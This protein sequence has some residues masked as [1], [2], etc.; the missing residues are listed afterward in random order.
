MLDA[1]DIE[2]YK[3][4]QEQTKEANAEKQQMLAE[5]KVL[6]KQGEEKLQKY[7][8]TSFSDIPKLKTKL[9]ELETQ[10]LKER[11]EMKEYCNY[12]ATKKMEKMTLFNTGG[13][14]V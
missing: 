11:D 3:E 14:L 5:I 1:K 12:I 9:E 4:L 13:E 7:G 2:E 10:V 8:F 6:K